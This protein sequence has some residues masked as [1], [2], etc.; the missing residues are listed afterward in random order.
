MRATHPH[1]QSPS[2]VLQLYYGSSSNFTFLSHVHAHLPSEEDSVGAEGPQEEVQ[3]GNAWLDIYKYQ[4]LAFGDSSDQRD[5]TITFLRAELAER[6]LQ[7]YLKTAYHL[8]PFLSPEQ[9]CHTFDKMYSTA[10]QDGNVEQSDRALILAALAIG[11]C[12]TTHHHLRKALLFQYYAHCEFIEGR[13]NSA[14]LYL[15]TTV[16]KAFAAGLHKDASYDKQPSNKSGEAHRTCWSMLVYEIFICM[17]LGRPSSISQEDINLPLPEKTTFLSAAVRLCDIMR[18]TKQMYHSHHQGVSIAADLKAAHRIRQRLVSYYH[19]IR[20][21]LGVTIGGPF[22][23]GDKTVFLIMLSYM[24]HYT[25]LLAFRPF[26]LLR[27][28]LKKRSR[29]QERCAEGEATPPFVSPPW[30]IDAGEHSVESARSIV[31]LSEAAFSSGLNAEGIYNHAFF[32]ESAS[33]VL[34]L[35]SLH[36]ER[37]TPSRH[38]RFVHRA[39]AA[40]RQ[41][42]SKEPILSI[43]SALEKMLAKVETVSG[44]H[45]SLSSSNDNNTQQPQTTEAGSDIPRPLGPTNNEPDPRRESTMNTPTAATQEQPN[46]QTSDTPMPLT[47]PADYPFLG[48]FGS[49]G[50]GSSAGVGDEQTPGS[51]IMPEFEWPQMDWNFDLSNLDLESFVSVMGND[52]GYP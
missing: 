47:S 20:E 43:I 41:M 30:L 7:N 52:L 17:T 27:A 50:D 18:S 21:D 16:R 39:I 14:Y 34:I 8:F 11:A 32:L 31:V 37:S 36:D 26:L 51:L 38:V 13:P 49:L 1:D 46:V 28:E 9:L 40:L 29:A 5:T 15:G 2:C 25:M 45:N 44:S 6:F 42:K 3:N 48:G 4:G 23:V 19:R 12:P 24:Y 22:Q 33:F 10:G 35:A